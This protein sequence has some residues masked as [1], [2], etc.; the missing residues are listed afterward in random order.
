MPNA[1]QEA[2]EDSESR[3]MNGRLA[4]FFNSRRGVP[5]YRESVSFDWDVAPLPRADFEVNILHTD[6]YCLPSASKNK[7]CCLDLH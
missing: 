7:G 1:E 6:G 4:M 2:A 3:F 5:T